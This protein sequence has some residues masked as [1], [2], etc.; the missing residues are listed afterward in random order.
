MFR[1][2]IIVAA[3]L[4][5]PPSAR[6]EDLKLWE[7]GGMYFGIPYTKGT[8]EFDYNVWYED[9]LPGMSLYGSYAFSDNLTVK[10]ELPAE[11][12]LP[13]FYGGKGSVVLGR[14]SSLGDQTVSFD[15]SGEVYGGAWWSDCVLIAGVNGARLWGKFALLGRVSA[16]SEWYGENDTI[17]L[18]GLGETEIGLFRYTGDFG[19]VGIPIMTEYRM[20]YFS[21]N[22]A[23]DW[24]LYLPHSL[25]LWLVPRYEV[26]GESGF[27]LWCGVAWM[28]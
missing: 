17:D 22:V 16:G 12:E 3:L 11:F 7:T 14:L 1:K 9:R 23:L 21:I 5:F 13:V 25:S 28:R 26:L 19:M 2:N 6:G 8:I 20:E 27:S 18:S 15:F 4:A 10:F 24:E